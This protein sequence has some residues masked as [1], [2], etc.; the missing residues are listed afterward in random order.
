MH[1]QVLTARL[2]YIRSNADAVVHRQIY[3]L[4]LLLCPFYT[5]DDVPPFS[6]GRTEI[7]FNVL[8]PAK[9][10]RTIGRIHRDEYPLASSLAPSQ[11][12]SIYISAYLF[13][14]F[15]KD[16]KLHKAS[17]S[18]FATTESQEENVNKAENP[19]QEPCRG[20]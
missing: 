13:C 20:A 18:N 14:L 9:L 15:S 6:R 7:I 11:K 2:C 5:P 1:Y 4:F 17:K 19:S 3:Y 10:Q 16:S 8:F 12:R